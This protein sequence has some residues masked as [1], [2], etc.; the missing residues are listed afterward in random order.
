MCACNTIDVTDS[1][2][3]N[4]RCGGKWMM[5]CV[6]FLSFS[7][8]YFVIYSIQ[9]RKKQS[10]NGIRAI[11]AL[12]QNQVYAIKNDEN[13]VLGKEQMKTRKR[14]QNLQLTSKFKVLQYVSGVIIIFLNK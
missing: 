12:T 6:F 10:I 13:E 14:Q 3:V 2:N 9:N 1:S 4:A 5:I 7:I 11:I 8:I